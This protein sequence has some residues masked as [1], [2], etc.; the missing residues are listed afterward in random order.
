MRKR[1]RGARAIKPSPSSL[2]LSG[3]DQLDRVGAK[4]LVKLNA[5]EMERDQARKDFDFVKFK[6]TRLLNEDQLDAAK[7][8]GIEPWM[9][10]IECI[11][12]YKEKFFPQMPS[13]LRPLMELKTGQF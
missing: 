3:I 4:L 7:T 11:E 12:L 8:C 5:A 2:L 13:H 1:R 6:L 10:A 9:Y